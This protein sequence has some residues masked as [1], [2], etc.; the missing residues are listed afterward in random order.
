MI[1][2]LV[3]QDLVYYHLR[4]SKL[5]TIFE[6]LESD[7]EVQTLLK[8]SNVMAVNRLHYNDH[9]P[10]H[11]RIV[12]GSA[13]EIFNNTMDTITPSIVEDKVG[14]INDARIVVLCGAYLHDIGNAVHRENH[15]IHGVLLANGI[16]TRLLQKIY[17]DDLE[18]SIRIKSETLHSIYAHQEGVRCLST[19]AGIA[20]IADGTD[21]A[22]GRA[23]IPYRIGKVDIHSLSALSIKSVE[24]F[25][26]ENQP[27]QIIVNMDNP[28]GVFQIEGILQEKIETSG[29]E[30]KVEVVAIVNDQE[31]K[32][33]RF[34]K[35]TI[36]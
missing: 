6:L 15:Y 22:Q 36:I 21:M 7:S 27:I 3:S 28:S 16:L 19:E 24:I 20:K 17:S 25:K 2:V 5:R 13:L 12:S 11:S 10:V 18:R 23:R 35:A 4:S 30:D 14:D 29:I 33:L 8:M 34:D 32:R 31:L 9:G 26:G 1:M